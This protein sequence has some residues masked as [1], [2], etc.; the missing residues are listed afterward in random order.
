MAVGDG[1][2]SFLGAGDKNPGGWIVFDQPDGI[3]WFNMV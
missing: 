1:D 2:H 3:I